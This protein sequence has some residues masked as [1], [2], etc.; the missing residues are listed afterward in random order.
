MAQ[1]SVLGD[2]SGQSSTTRPPFAPHPVAATGEVAKAVEN[3]EVD[4]TPARVAVL[5]DEQVLAVIVVAGSDNWTLGMA[6]PML[7]RMWVESSTAVNGARKLR[8]GS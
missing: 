5:V 8:I 7:V 2:A 1:S 6:R 4:V 3:V